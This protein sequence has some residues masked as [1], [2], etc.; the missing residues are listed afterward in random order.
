[1][2]GDAGRVYFWIRR[3]DLAATDFECAWAVLQR[4]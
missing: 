4:Y 2:W 1:M 3:Q